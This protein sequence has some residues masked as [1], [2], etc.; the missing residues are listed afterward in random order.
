MNIQEV[1]MTIS[2]CL[3]IVAIIIGPILAVQVQ[4]FIENRKEVKSRKMFC[5]DE[6]YKN[7]LFLSIGNF[8]RCEVGLTRS[9]DDFRRIPGRF[10]VL[11]HF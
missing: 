5:R 3:V 6:I 10:P 1:I 2:N 9:R 4:K 11:L 8:Q 7:L